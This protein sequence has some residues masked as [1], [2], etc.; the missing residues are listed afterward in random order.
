MSLALQMDGHFGNAK[1]RCAGPDCPKSFT[2]V[3]STRRFCSTKCRVAHHRE[4]AGRRHVTTT[5]HG[6]NADLIAAA[7][8]LYIPNGALVADVT[9]GRGVFWQK[10]GRRRFTVVGS[11]LI[12]DGG[13]LRADFCRLPYRDGTFDVVAFDP[14]YAHHGHRWEPM[15]KRYNGK[16]TTFEATCA[17]ILELYR[18]GMIEARRVLKPRGRLLVKCQDQI[19]SGKQFWFSRRI[20]E[21]AEHLGMV[22]ATCSCWSRARR[23]AQDAGKDGRRSTRAKRTPI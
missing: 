6:T 21:L 4:A 14:P 10:T 13:R 1:V 20:P 3:R 5:V 12:I 7:A 9:Y 8:K 16:A 15:E 17:D 19:E 11:D 23:R 18:V 2:P 22:I